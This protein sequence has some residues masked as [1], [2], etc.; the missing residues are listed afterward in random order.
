MFGKGIFSR[1]DEESKGPQSPLKY[2]LLRPP[3]ELVPLTILHVSPKQG[4]LGPI[5]GLD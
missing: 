2:Q 4:V 1:G 3:S 5:P